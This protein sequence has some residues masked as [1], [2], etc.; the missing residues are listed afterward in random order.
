MKSVGW[1]AAIVC[2]LLVGCATTQSSKL[3]SSVDV[4]GPWTGAWINAPGSAA[5][6]SG[7]VTYTLQ[8]SGSEVT[9]EIIV[10]GF[11]AFSGPIRGTVKGNTFEYTSPG[12]GGWLTVKGDTMSGRSRLSSTLMLQRQQQ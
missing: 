7:D 12:S 5:A 4:T 6:G 2:V 9:G 10:H 3:A 8:Q 11:P 1:P